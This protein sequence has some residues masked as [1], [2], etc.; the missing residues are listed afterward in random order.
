MFTF[1]AIAFEILWLS[2]LAD[3]TKQNDYLPFIKKYFNI[4]VVIDVVT[5]N[6][7]I[8]LRGTGEEERKRQRKNTKTYVC[9][10]YY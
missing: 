10:I 1:F 9:R 8:L 3:N 4:D 5:Y 2:V 6:K 7:N